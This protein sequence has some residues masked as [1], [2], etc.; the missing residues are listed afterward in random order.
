MSITIPLDR[1]EILPG[2][3]LCLHQID[4]QRFEAILAELGEK[5]SSRIAFCGGALEIRMPLPEHECA[6][7]LIGDLLKLLLD[8]LE[9]EWQSLGSTTFKKQSALAGLEPDDCFYIRNYRVAIGMK[10]VDLNIDPP[11]DLAIEVDLTSKTQVSAYEAIGVPEIWRCDRGKLIIYL[12]QNGAYQESETSS[13]FPNI[14]I[15]I[16]ISQYLAKIKTLPMSTIRREF[17]QWLN[18]HLGDQSC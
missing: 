17:R 11:P 6:K 18:E 7:V 9:M 1:I 2:Q 5:R 15:M 3:R 12:L 4:W 14:P 13:I 8:H 10:R 16:G